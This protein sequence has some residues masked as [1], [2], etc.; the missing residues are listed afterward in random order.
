[1][2]ELAC[3]VP[4]HGGLYAY[5][6]EGFGSWLAFLLAYKEVLFDNPS[7]LAVKS[8]TFS[9][10]FVKTFDL[11]GTPQ[12]LVSL[13]AVTLIG[14]TYSLLLII[15]LIIVILLIINKHHHWCCMLLTSSSSSS[16]SFTFSILFLS[17]NM[18]ISIMVIIT[19]HG[20]N[21]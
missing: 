4:K 7:G 6:R 8:L 9:R 10:Y 2:S 20:D 11:C 21:L 16:V 12:T 15:I 18:S 1:M 5:I 17:F 13:V 3:R 14:E 19:R